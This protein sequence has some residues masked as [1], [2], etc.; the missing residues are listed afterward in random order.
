MAREP[1]GIQHA[2]PLGVDDGPVTLWMN[3][4]S[5]G[6]LGVVYLVLAVALVRLVRS[7]GKAAPAPWMYWAS[8]IFS[9]TCG[10]T[11]LA[12]I[13]TRWSPF[14]WT[15]AVLKTSC[16]LASLVTIV[17]FV[18]ALPAIIAKLAEAHR[19]RGI[20]QTELASRT[21]ELD[22]LATELA[23][24]RAEAEAARE[25]ATRA[26]RM[27]SDF[28]SL[29]SH[30]LGTPATALRLG[31]ELLNAEPFDSER[32]KDMARR[33]G[34]AS[35]R[36]LH[37]SQ[38]MLDYASLHAGGAPTRLEQ[39]SLNDLVRDIADQWRSRATAKGITLR[40]DT[41]PRKLSVRTDAQLLRLALSHLV[42]DAVEFTQSGTVEVAIVDETRGIVVTVRDTGPGLPEEVQ[43]RLFDPFVHG[44]PIQ[45]KHAPGLGL[46]LAIV[47]HA[48]AG[49]AGS[50]ELI[51][52]SERGTTFAVVLPRS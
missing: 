45:R 15:G 46:G 43:R 35:E 5:D 11:H 4:L 33:V 34:R 17:L 3:I 28:I 2:Q 6:V 27:K 47:R 26:S 42:R 8:A 18:L 49:L 37:I 21:G 50:V 32:G 38:T 30:E 40:F 14:S 1:T 29:I 48:I 22:T 51:E 24:S 19:A 52:T 12:S 39:I 41:S 7:A 9:V 36:L 31:V 13:A 20:L 16:A 10:L 44:E 23:A 25:D